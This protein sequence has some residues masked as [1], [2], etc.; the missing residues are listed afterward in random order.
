MNAELKNVKL[1]IE[2]NIEMMWDNKKVLNEYKPSEPI[3]P[4]IIQWSNFISHNS[5]TIKSKLWDKKLQLPF[6]FLWRE[7][8]TEVQDANSEIWGGKNAKTFLRILSSHLGIQFFFFSY[9]TSG[10]FS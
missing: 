6:L 1:V 9:L 2:Q 7:K 8:K 10:F 3:V 5:D 4:I